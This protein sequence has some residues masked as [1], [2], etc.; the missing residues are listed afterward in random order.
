MNTLK[1][2]LYWSIITEKKHILQ[3]FMGLFFAYLL[4]YG[5]F[6]GFL[7]NMI[8]YPFTGRFDAI[9]TSMHYLATT[10]CFVVLAIAFEVLTAHLFSNLWTKQGRAQ[11][12]M[13]PATNAQKFWSRVILAVTTATV[14]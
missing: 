3:V 8:S 4:A 5:L 14:V 9:D 2:T 6:S 13:L 7:A 1:N 12:F 11:F 10:I